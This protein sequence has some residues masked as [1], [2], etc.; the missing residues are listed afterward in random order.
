MRRGGSTGMLAGLEGADMSSRLS[1]P[2]HDVS[3][4]PAANEVLITIGAR[5]NAPSP[6]GQ[7]DYL[8]HIA[9]ERPGR[10][11][12]FEESVGRGPAPG[13]GAICLSLSELDAWPGN[14]RDHLVRAGCGW[15]AEVID[16]HGPDDHTAVITEI[17]K[18]HKP[19]AASPE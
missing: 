19:H 9:L 11:F 17:L 1:P 18:R 7:H 6:G 8:F 13:G 4:V 10:P 3:N 15:V 5:N 12:C 2:E 16:A 14:W